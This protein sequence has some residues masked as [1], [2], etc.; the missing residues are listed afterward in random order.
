MSGG[1]K[2]GLSAALRRAL[3]TALRGERF[4]YFHDQKA[5]Y[6]FARSRGSNFPEA[7]TTAMPGSPELSI[8]DRTRLLLSGDQ[9]VTD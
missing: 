6:P 7:A 9:M 1:E 2:Q 8:K 3:R 4:F 5:K